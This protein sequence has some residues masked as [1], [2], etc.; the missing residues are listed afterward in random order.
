MPVIDNDSHYDPQVR[1]TTILDT[2]EV[3]I[4][5]NAIPARRYAIDNDFGVADIQQ[6]F[7]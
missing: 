5:L 1:I 7:S 2:N 4:V 3:R 6:D